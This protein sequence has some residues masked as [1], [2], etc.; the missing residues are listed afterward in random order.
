MIISSNK[1]TLI[2]LISIRLLINGQT[3]KSYNGNFNSVNFQGTASYKYYEDNSEQRIYV[4]PFIF[5]GT[6]AAINVSGNYV[7]NLKSGSWSTLVTNVTTSDV[8]MKYNIT[9]TVTG[10]YDKGNLDGSWTL[11]RTKVM[12]FSESGISNFYKT[13]IRMFSYLFDEKK[14]DFSKSSTAYE[15][16]VVNF[17]NNKFSGNFIYSINK[18]KSIVKGQF[19]ENGY[20]NGNW[21]ITYYNDGVLISQT[22]NYLK[23][24]LLT[25]KVKDNSTGEITTSY[26]KSKEVYEFFQNYNEKENY[27]KS[28]EGYLKL[29]ESTST[30]DN[31]K[32]LEDA[33]SIWFNNRS[34]SK[35]SY[36]FEI[37]HGA[38]P[39]TLYP[40]RI[41]VLNEE[42]NKEQVK[43]TEQAE[44]LEEEKRIKELDAKNEEERK[45]R[46]F[47]RSDYGKL[48]KSV[49][50]EFNVWLKKT[51][52]ETN[53]DF[54]NRI[55]NQADEKFQNIINDK[56]NK[57]K[58]EGSIINYAKIGSYYINIESFPIF[59]GSQSANIKVSKV[60][61]P[62]FY[63]KFASRKGGFDKPTIYII[64]SDFIML[65][66]SWQ[67]SK[68]LIILDGFWTGADFVRNEAFK[69]F[70]KEND[71]YYYDKEE[72]DF[73]TMRNS[74]KKYK[75]ISVND[76][77][78]ASD[79]KN[80]V[81]YYEYI[82]PPSPESQSLNFN[83]KD[84]N[85]TLPQF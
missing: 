70:Y 43:L 80:E 64:P 40:E 32:F 14:I 8:I 69:K 66:N 79:I 23:G 67:V 55:K 83:Y 57:A 62:D 34:V 84:L 15:S 24:V 2:F 12:S 82:A 74:I 48:Q 77:K 9:A 50:D 33:I 71:K 3:V 72:P 52:I 56:I 63:K 19:D 53:S 5:K 10:M 73:K 68:A 47:N 61:E 7:N 46:E 31:D 30:I 29:T 25:V 54:E 78:T 1:L 38:N 44:M 37:E 13:Q 35:S 4:G 36:I 26:D 45:N 51:E 16:S 11:N 58:Q 75:M 65:N 41:I 85:I 49:K 59:F 81:Y 39:L 6:K 28:S 60:I 76:I 22:K 17:S 20:F 27:S 42:K 18:G 21:S